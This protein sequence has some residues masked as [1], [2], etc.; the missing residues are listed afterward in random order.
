MATIT[1]PP[2]A[3]TAAATAAM[4]ADLAVG[5][6]VLQ[7]HAEGVGLRRH[8]RREPATHLDAERLGARRDHVERLREHVVG[9]EDGAAALDA[10]TR[11]AS[12]IAS[13]AAVASSSIDALA[14]AM[15]V[16]SQT[17]VWK[18]ISASRRPC[19]ISGWY[20]V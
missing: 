16:R 13:A 20:G 15:P 10:V 5:A 11:S 12:V 14:I 6:R 2:R 9:D 18:L 4:V 1:K 3:C 7:Q 17:I 19:E 8:R